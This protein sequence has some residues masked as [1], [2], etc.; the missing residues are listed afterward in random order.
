MPA[1]LTL[2]LDNEPVVRNCV[3]NDERLSFFYAATEGM[4]FP[5]SLGNGR[6]Y[7]RDSADLCFPG[8]S[9]RHRRSRREIT[10]GEVIADALDKRARNAAFSPA[11]AFARSL[12]ASAD[13]SFSRF[14]SNTPVF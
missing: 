4:A 1:D 6:G 8:R 14:V 2:L 9:V 3:E 5:S 13:L 12:I 7:T 10:R 11:W